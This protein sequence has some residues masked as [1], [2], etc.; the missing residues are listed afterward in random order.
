MKTSTLLVK[1]KR[2]F[3]TQLTFGVILLFSFCLTQAQT[4][5]YITPEGN[6]EKDG[7]SWSNAASNLYYWINNAPADAEIWLKQGIYKPHPS[8]RTV[9]FSIKSGVKVYG[10]FAGTE[11][12]LSQRNYTTNV[13]ILSGE[14]GASASDDNSYHVI[15]V[16][17]TTNASTTIIDGIT[18]SNGN[19]NGTTSAT[20]IG[21][22]A[23]L[24]TN[25]AITFRNCKF[26]NNS[27]YDDGGAIY[28]KSASVFENCEFSGNGCFHP[29]AFT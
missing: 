21:A 2:N 3:I 1:P 29:G 15:Y 8:D 16:I 9:S 17:A 12:M 26:S 4:R 22:G 14:I 20:R 11:T 7:T 24:D 28:L 13:T 18:I 5:I 6:G 10:G 23:Y 27:S 25:S 19:A